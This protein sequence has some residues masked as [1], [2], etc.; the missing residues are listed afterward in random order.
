MLLSKF[1][2][3]L[4]PLSVPQKIEM[5][6]ELSLIL[7]VYCFSSTLRASFEQLKARKLNTDAIVLYFFKCR[8][9]NFA[10][11]L[12]KSRTSGTFTSNCLIY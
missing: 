5:V 4:L 10:V 3:N 7:N 2:F 11:L 1:I 6:D 12:Q 9:I 8:M